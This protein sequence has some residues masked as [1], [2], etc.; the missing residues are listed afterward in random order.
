M[1]REIAEFVSRC[2]VCQQIKVEHKRPA[3]MLN[4]LPIPQLKWE[5]VSMDGLYYGITEN[6]E[7]T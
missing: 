6:S 1:R 7:K 2:L 4:P 3:G 5:H